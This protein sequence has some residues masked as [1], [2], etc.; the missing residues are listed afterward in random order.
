V[1]LKKEE[2]DIDIGKIPSGIYKI[3]I[4]TPDNFLNRWWVPKK[5]E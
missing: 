4:E 3:V 5:T 1:P 2:A